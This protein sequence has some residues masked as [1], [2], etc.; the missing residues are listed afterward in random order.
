MTGDGVNDAPALKKAD[1]G[2]AIANS[3]DAAR[4]APT[5]SFGFMLLSLFYGSLIF[6]LSWCS[7]L[8]SVSCVED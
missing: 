7:S 5:L 3:T 1:I 8:Q 6:H 2:I 4:S